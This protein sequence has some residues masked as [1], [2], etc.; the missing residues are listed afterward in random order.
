MVGRRAAVDNKHTCGH[1][2]LEVSVEYPV[3]EVQKEATEVLAP[4]FNRAG[5]TLWAP[6]PR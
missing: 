6:A 2:E 1:V 4:E 3:R 5:Y